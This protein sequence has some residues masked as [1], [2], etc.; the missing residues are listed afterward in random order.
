MRTSGRTQQPVFLLAC[1][2]YD[3]I[4]QEHSTGLVVDKPRDTY[5]TSS[6]GQTPGGRLRDTLD[7]VAKHLPMALGT[8]LA[9]RPE[10][11]YRGTADST[12]KQ[13]PGWKTDTN[14]SL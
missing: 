12:V 14:G 5:H 4:L 10:S 11:F 2:L 3:D 7:V 13:D 8:P 6:A 9:P 1:S